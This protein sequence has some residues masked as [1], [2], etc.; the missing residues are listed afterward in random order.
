MIQTKKDSAIIE[1]LDASRSFV[2]GDEIVEVLKNVNLRIFQGEFLALMGASGS[3]KSTLLN[4]LGC[5]DTLST[6][7]YWLGGKS[8]KNLSNNKR[9]VVRNTHIGFV[10]QN[11]NL[12]PRMT[13]WENIALPLLYRNI[14]ENEIKEKVNHLLIQ[15]DLSHRKNHI[16]AQLSGGERQRVAI[17][18]ALI[19][20]PTVLLADEPT[21]NLDSKT[22]TEIM[23][24][25]V[26]L[27]QQGRSIIMVTHD[28]TI[29]G[30]ANRQLLM[31]DGII[32]EN[33]AG[34]L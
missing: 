8:I 19:T 23:R 25:L 11:F 3:G 4:V 32:C 6:G 1:L 7:E 29:A 13:T 9:A 34:I 30:Y 24:L 20:N 15:I 17:A 18:R 27:N 10:F 2:V 14:S 12:L 21:G 28:Q 22:G 5:L 16:P 26:E 31:K 33:A